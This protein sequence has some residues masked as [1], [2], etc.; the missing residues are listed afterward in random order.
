[1]AERV[2]QTGQGRVFLQQQGAGPAFPLKYQGLARMGGFDLG[3]SE[4]TRVQS[5]SPVAYDEFVDIDE[6][7]GE[8]SR[9]TTSMIARLSLDNPILE[10][11]CPIHVQV[12]WGKCANPQDLNRGWELAFAYEHAVFTGRSGDEQTAIDEAGRATIL[13]TGTLSARKLWQLK[14]MSLSEVSAAQVAAEVVAVIAN[15]YVSCGECG[16]VSDGSQRFF[17]VVKGGTLASPGLYAEV[18]ASNDKGQTIAEYTITTLGGGEQPVAGAVIGQYL[19]VPS[20]DSASIHI[21]PLSDLTAWQEVA[22][23]FGGGL[24]EPTAITDVTASE[25]WIAGMDGYV[26]KIDNPADG[27]AI[28]HA[29]VLTTEHLRAIHACSSRDVLAGGANGALI[30]SYNGGETWS[31]PALSPTVATITSV[32]MRTKY[33]WFVCDNAGNLYYTVNGGAAWTAKSFAMAGLGSVNGIS[34]ASHPDAPIGFIAATNAAGKG[35]I[36]R[37]LDGGNSWYQL[38]DTANTTPANGGLSS[39]SAGASGNFVVAGGLK[40]GIDGIVIVGA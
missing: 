11:T 36:F 22:T 20:T 27:V 37:T 17:A 34:F 2:F 3:G 9:P 25:G 5:P 8:S 10:A 31:E 14:N 32:W 24:G 29:G 12:H 7:R 4:P 13:V 1:M 30:V 33:C 18:I 15:D 28:Q 35:F 26:Y 19:V 23:G 39:I 21:A 40:T 38:P 6:V 16:Y